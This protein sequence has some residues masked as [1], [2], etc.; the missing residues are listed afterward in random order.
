MSL[1]V[2]LSVRHQLYNTA[3]RAFGLQNLGYK[4]VSMCWKLNTLFICLSFAV[5][6][7]LVQPD[8]CRTSSSN[9]FFVLL[10]FCCRCFSP[11]APLN[12]HHF[13]VESR[14]CW[15]VECRS[16]GVGHLS[17]QCMA[18]GGSS[19][20]GKEKWASYVPQLIISA[21]AS[22]LQL[23]R[24]LGSFLIKS[25]LLYFTQDDLITFYVGV[26]D[27]LIITTFWPCSLP[28]NSSE[29]SPIDL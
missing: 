17:H 18:G 10:L 1:R 6:T 5:R 22:Y 16:Q 4:E 27:C 15:G 13:D 9:R 28:I 3:K 2:K 20:E 21:L 26:L 12:L 19:G 24:G 23:A 8:P 11:E 7:Q 14:P 25:Q 29:L